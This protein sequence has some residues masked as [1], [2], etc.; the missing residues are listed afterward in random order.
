MLARLRP[1]RLIFELARFLRHRPAGQQQEIH[2]VPIFVGSTRRDIPCGWFGLP[3]TFLAMGSTPI[4]L[5]RSGNSSSALLEKV[6]IVPP[7][8]DVDTFTD[9]AN[10]VW[11]KANG[12][13]VSTSAAPDPAW[14]GKLW[15]LPVGST[16]PDA[17]RLWEDEPR[18]WVWEPVTDMPLANYEAALASVNPHFVKIWFEERI[19]MLLSQGARR[20]I[21]VAV[22]ELGDPARK[23]VW[24]TWSTANPRVRRA[25]D[26]WD[27]TEAPVPSDVVAIALFALDEMARRKRIRVEIAS[28]EDEISELDNDLSHIKAVVARLLKERPPVT[29]KTPAWFW[30]S[31]VGPV[32]TFRREIIAVVCARVS[33]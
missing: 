24:R 5:F 8:D 19:M 25:G 11:V 28:T 30:P 33:G 12:R 26:P 22:D 29:H 17:L 21:E 1:K 20:L 15:R 32:Q 27:D 6:R 10:A 23:E 16:Y 13:G 31:K 9:A 14:R 18:H 3:S 2:L 4:D 7:N